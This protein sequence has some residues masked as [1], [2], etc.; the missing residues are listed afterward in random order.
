MKELE[1][2]KQDPRFIGFNFDGMDLKDLGVIRDNKR[3][4]EILVKLIQEVQ[5]H[6]AEQ[7]M[8][9]SVNPSTLDIS[10]KLVL[11]TRQEK[12]RFRFTLENLAQVAHLELK[13]RN[14]S[15]AK[16]SK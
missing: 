8:K 9:Q 12:A 11:A 5:I 16:D 10:E 6:E 3:V 1:E 15:N 4:L 2:L 14:G 7:V 13:Q